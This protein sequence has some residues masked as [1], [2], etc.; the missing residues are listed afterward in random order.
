MNTYY[1]FYS[2]LDY[3]SNKNRIG[4]QETIASS[5]SKAKSNVWYRLEEYTG[6]YG[7]DTGPINIRVLE[8]PNILMKASVF[9]LPTKSQSS[10]VYWH[11]GIIYDN[12]VFEAH[13]KNSYISTEKDRLPELNKLRAKIFESYIMPKQLLIHFKDSLNSGSYI[14]KALNLSQNTEYSPDNIY[15]HITGKEPSREEQPEF[16]FKSFE[17]TV[18]NYKNRRLINQETEI[19]PTLEPT[20][21]L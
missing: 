4:L 3:R 10:N 8:Y 17:E 9:F 11:T 1:V 6:K 2:F 13:N 18:N 7:M 5:A 15:R 19:N 14:A 12:L 21:E 20:Q 16:Q